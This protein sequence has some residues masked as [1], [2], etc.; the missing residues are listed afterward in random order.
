[1]TKVGDKFWQEHS[2][3][4]SEGF[5]KSLGNE[6]PYDPQICQ[7]YWTSAFVRLTASHFSNR[8]E[9]LENAHAAFR[10]VSSHCVAA[11]RT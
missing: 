7:F 8:G 2:G 1:L 5:Q 3:F 10:C 9:G 4:H 11:T 6:I